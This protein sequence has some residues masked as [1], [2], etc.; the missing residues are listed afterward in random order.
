VMLSDCTM[1]AKWLIEGKV[2]WRRIFIFVVMY[3][4]IKSHKAILAIDFMTD[5]QTFDYCLAFFF[6]KIFS[7]EKCC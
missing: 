1:A 6:P 5:I 4:L 3:Y 7:Y 2:G